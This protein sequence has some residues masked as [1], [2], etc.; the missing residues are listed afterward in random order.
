MIRSA[1]NHKLK[2]IRKL[3]P[4]ALARASSACSR[5]RARTWWRRPR[6]RLGAG[7]RAARRRGRGA[8]AARRGEHARLGQPRDRR[9]PAALVASRAGAL[10]VYLHGVDDPGNVG[11]IIRSAHALAD[12]PVVLGPGLR[13]PVLAEGGAGQHGLAVRPAAGARRARRAGGHARRARRRTAERTLAE[14]RAERARRALPGR[15]A[16]GAAGRAARRPT[17]GADPAAPDGPDSLN[18][19]M[20]ATVALYELAT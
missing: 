5:P 20:A 3:Q 14:R 7:V 9:L 19:A 6:G 13:R 18:V 8:R 11:T 12:G 16:R 17:R 10:L 2:T 1:D 15:R 4:E